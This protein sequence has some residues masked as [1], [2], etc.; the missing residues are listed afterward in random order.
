MV[1]NIYTVR[2]VVAEMVSPPFWAKNDKHAFR[3]FK[4]TIEQNDEGD[5]F[6]L[7]FI[8]KIDDETGVLEALGPANISAKL[9]LV[10]G[11]EDE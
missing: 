3:M 8:G 9:S 2:D 4:K 1:R 11:D 7:L 6:E 10:E 5:D